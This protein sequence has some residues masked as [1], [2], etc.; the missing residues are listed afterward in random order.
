MQSVQITIIATLLGL[1][2]TTKQII[3]VSKLSAIVIHHVTN[4]TELMKSV[5][6]WK[7]NPWGHSWR[8]YEVGILQYKLRFALC[9]RRLALKFLVNWS[10]H[11]IRQAIYSVFHRA[12]I[13]KELDC[14]NNCTFDMTCSCQKFAN[15]SLQ[16]CNLL[17]NL[18]KHY[19]N[20]MPN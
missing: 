10:F 19:V 8:R 9:L 11:A 15:I 2:I 4:I 16:I 13:S 1:K 18:H 17:C 7:K 3:V 5:L 14:K 20:C 12:S 6:I